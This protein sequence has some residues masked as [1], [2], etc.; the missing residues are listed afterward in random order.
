MAEKPT[1]G[2]PSLRSTPGAYDDRRLVEASGSKFSF[3]KERLLEY[4]SLSMAMLYEE[5]V[6]RA[7]GPTAHP[8]SVASRRLAGAAALLL[9][10]A[11]C[12]RFQALELPAGPAH[13]QPHHQ[14]KHG[15]TVA[16][17]L[18]K[19]PLVI[20][21]HFGSGLHREGFLPV[22][23]FFEN[24]GPGSFEIERKKLFLILEDG[25]RLEPVSPREVFLAMRQSMLPAY[26]LAPLV[27]PA[28]VLYRSVEEHNF[29]TARN[30]RVKSLPPVL[31]LESGDPPLSRAVY[32]RDPRIGLHPPRSFDSSVLQALVEIDGSRLPSGSAAPDAGEETGPLEAVADSSRPPPPSPT[33][34]KL[35]TFSVSLDEEEL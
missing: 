9:A 20:K 25:E 14:D 34:G 8:P 13:T 29:E 12:A 21:H 7:L 10:G 31:R 24:R 19:D 15:L 23:V 28:I 2:K 22:I 33:V 18:L 5:R 27:L 11:G 26:L 3:G 30:L 4:S 6:R 35:L 16:A 1:W 17:M 32:F